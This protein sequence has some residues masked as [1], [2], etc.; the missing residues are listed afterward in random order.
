MILWC[1]QLGERMRRYE[2]Q[3]LQGCLFLANL[4]QPRGSLH[5]IRAQPR[6]GGLHPMQELKVFP[7]VLSP[8][9]ELLGFC[10]HGQNELLM[11][12]NNET[13]EIFLEMM[14]LKCPNV[15]YPTFIVGRR[16]E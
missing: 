12:Y 16:P 4:R 7:Q 2:E 1:L 3:S 5:A 8:F 15:I 10:G 6:T 11:E 13:C 9:R 14:T